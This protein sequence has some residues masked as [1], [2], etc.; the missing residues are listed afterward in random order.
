[1][2]KLPESAVMP[3]TVLAI[4]RSYEDRQRRADWRR[5]HLG[6]SQIGKE[7]DRA[8]W[9]GFRWATAPT[10]DGRMLRL[11]DTGNR[12]ET[13]L[14]SDLRRVGVEVHEFEEGT[15][16]QFRV[17]DIGGHFGGSLDGA[18]RGF[19]ESSAW[20]VL[21]FK[22]S[23]A[24][25]FAE[26]KRIGVEK[27]KPQHYVQMQVYMHLTGMTRA[28]YFAVCKDTDAI[29]GE[30]V[31]YHAPS[32]WRTIE[33]ARRIIQSD[34]APPRISENPHYPECRWCE[35]RAVCHEGALPLVSCRTCVHATPEM[36]GDGRW[37]CARGLDSIPPA[38]QRAGC[39]DHLYLPT[40]TPWHP[41]DANEAEN[42]ITYE[43]GHKN[44]GPDGMTS[45]EMREMANAD[46]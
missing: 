22:T 31:R 28:Y 8:I 11:F 30:R 27:A 7:C 40:M 20:H 41:V 6:A 39:P 33:R 44:G 24:R 3:A 26:L 45:M 35:H 16:R 19:A 36:D 17:S 15:R 37:S 14:V 34:T 1:M 5:D 42:S 4:F 9:Y 13:R 21:E 23:N 12:E 38:A 29:H 25:G 43:G 32:A 46:L 18:A 2:A 10:F